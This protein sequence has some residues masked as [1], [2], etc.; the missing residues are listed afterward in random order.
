[1]SDSTLALKTGIT[2]LRIVSPFYLIICLKL[3][4]DGVL[5][6]AG[7]VKA[8]MA[9]TFSDLILRVILSYILSVPFGVNGIWYSWPIG[10]LTATV[11]S[12]YFYMTGAWKIKRP[13]D[14]FE[15]P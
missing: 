6:G 12:L 1:S 9:T 15:E 8:F 14:E 4:A 2:F 10:W 11:L 7:A 5:R 13:V 3:M